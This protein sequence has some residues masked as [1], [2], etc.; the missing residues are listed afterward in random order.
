MFWCSETYQASKQ[1]SAACSWFCHWNH[2]Q[3]VYQ[4]ESKVF[5]A[6]T[7]PIPR[8]V[9]QAFYPW[10]TR[11]NKSPKKLP[12]IL[13]AI[14]SR[15]SYGQHSN[16]PKNRTDNHPEV[17]FC[18]LVPVLWT[19]KHMKGKICTPHAWGR[20]SSSACGLLAFQVSFQVSCELS[21]YVSFDFFGEFCWKI[22]SHRAIGIYSLEVLVPFL[23]QQLKLI[24]IIYNYIYIYICIL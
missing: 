2:L 8:A 6:K 18:W 16:P 13:D 10:E 14:C 23:Q 12:R 1:N 15:M 11:K 17:T 3:K 5:A 19:S 4:F 9:L 21:C 24:Q 20:I 7:L 22:T